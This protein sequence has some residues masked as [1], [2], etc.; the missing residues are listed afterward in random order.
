M[1]STRELVG[2]HGGNGAPLWEEV[3]VASTSTLQLNGEVDELQE[4]MV[5]WWASWRLWF[6]GGEGAR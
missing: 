6:D 3:N 5:E 1:V 4:A 2:A